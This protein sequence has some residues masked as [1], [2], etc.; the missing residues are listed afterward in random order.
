MCVL[1]CVCVCV[2]VCVCLC[3]LCVCVWFVCVWFVFSWLV[4]SAGC[5]P[6]GP[7]VLVLLAGLYANV[8]V[9][10]EWLCDF[11]ARTTPTAFAFLLI[12]L[13]HNYT[14]PFFASGGS[15]GQHLRLFVFVCLCLRQTALLGRSCHVLQNHAR[16][17]RL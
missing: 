9:S 6:P 1:A 14:F 4:F 3:G 7:F 5:T 2:C 16:P 13:M 12:G 10:I 17:I 11:G 15:K 8:H